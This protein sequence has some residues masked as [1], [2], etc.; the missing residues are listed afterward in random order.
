MPHPC[1]DSCKSSG[2]CAISSKAA[3]R[4]VGWAPHTDCPKPLAYCAGCLRSGWGTPRAAQLLGEAKQCSMGGWIDANLAT[5]GKTLE[6]GLYANCFAHPNN[7]QVPAEC[8]YCCTQPWDAV[9][10]L[11]AT[12]RHENQSPCTHPLLV[13][14]AT[15]NTTQPTAPPCCPAA[16]LGSSVAGRRRQWYSPQHSILHP[17]APCT[18][19]DGLGSRLAGRRL[20]LDPSS[21]LHPTS[22]CIFNGGPWQPWEQSCGAEAAGALPLQHSAPPGSSQSGHHGWSPH[23][24]PPHGRF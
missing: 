24:A 2:Q 17:A 23:G 13:H 5:R 16:G 14:H 1:S 6:Q 12:R 20:G 18:F 10:K 22:L 9:H 19:N 3:V 11:A 4:R 8:L 21:S 7:E 15:Q